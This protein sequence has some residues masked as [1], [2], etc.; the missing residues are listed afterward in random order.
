MSNAIKSRGFTL[1][2]PL[3][4][5]AIIGILAG[6]LWPALSHGFKF[7]LLFARVA[8]TCSRACP[9]IRLSYLFGR[10]RSSARHNGAWFWPQ[11]QRIQFGLRL[12]WRSFVDGIGI[13]FMR[14]C[15]VA[16]I[17]TRTQLT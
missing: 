9:K 10:Q 2:E 4:A 8:A 13:R 12:P 5:M 1:I 14:M 15:G 17:P 6:I 11:A 7:R 3:T 16:A